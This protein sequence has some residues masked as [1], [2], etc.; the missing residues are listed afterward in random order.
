MLAP[1]LQ[2]IEQACGLSHLNEVAIWTSHITADLHTSINRRSQ[3][4]CTLG[5]PLFILAL[6]SA[7]RIFKSTLLTA[8]VRMKAYVGRKNMADGIPGT[9]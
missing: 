3:K 2:H 7:T 6:I 8:N 1:P 5:F 9:W 4:F